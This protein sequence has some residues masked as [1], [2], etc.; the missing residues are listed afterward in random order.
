MQF[1]KKGAKLELVQD[2]L[3]NISS[4]SKVD[5]QAEDAQLVV[6][7][8]GQIEFESVGVPM[9]IGP[10]YRSKLVQYSLSPAMIC[11]SCLPLK[12]STTSVAVSLFKLSNIIKKYIYFIRIEYFK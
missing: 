4:T 11:Q 3:R 1:K 12:L 6:D 5:L 9:N 2:A 8:Q 10:K 7:Q